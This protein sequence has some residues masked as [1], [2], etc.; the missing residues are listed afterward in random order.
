MAQQQKTFVLQLAIT[1]TLLL[2]LSACSGSGQPGDIEPVNDLPTPTATLASDNSSSAADSSSQETTSEQP[3][4]TE[5]STPV[6]SLPEAADFSISGGVVGFCDSLKI[7]GGGEYVLE[8]CKRDAVTGPLDP[9]DLEILQNWLANFTAFQVATEN[10]SGGTDSLTSALVF[11]GIGTTEP[12]EAQKQMAVEWFNGLFIRLWPQEVEAPP[13]PTPTEVGADGLCPNVTRPALIIADF[14]NPGN[15]TVVDPNTLT[16]CNIALEQTPSGRIMTAAGNI[17]YPVFDPDT[18]MMTIWQV[19]ASGVQTPLEFTS[20]SMAGAG[21]FTYIISDDG[22][23]IAWARTGINPDVDP[24][25]F[26]ND[27][28]AANIDGSNQVTLIDQSENSQKQFVVPIRFSPGGSELFYAVQSD[29]QGFDLSGRFGSVYTILVT[30]G[31]GQLIFVCP[32]AENPIC[33]S[34]ITPDGTA[35]AYIDR[36]SSEVRVVS[37]DGNQLAALQAPVTE[38]VGSAL[39]GH[40]GNLA[41]VSAVFEQQSE[42]APP[43]PNPGIISFVSAPYA[44]QPQTL[45]SDNTVVTLWEWLDETR[46]AYGSLDEVGNV[47]TSVVNIDGQSSEIS[48]NYALAVLR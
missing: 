47:G 41:F 13:T 4:S 9:A 19:S 3:A 11:N 44:D 36:A 28:W 5:E 17:Y 29:A 35:L 20:I 39:F 2:T 6:E 18:E 14:Q 45:L 23:K 1:I 42:D 30:G 26:R 16:E 43:V 34:D 37:R 10:N 38:F 7:T 22:S 24:S 31:T 8:S 32:S 48:P 27:M 33:I 40:T 25:I 46:L 21:P 12:D 15:L